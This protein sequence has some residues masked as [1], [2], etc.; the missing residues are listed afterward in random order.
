MVTPQISCWD[1]YSPSPD[2]YVRNCTSSPGAFCDLGNSTYGLSPVVNSFSGS[3]PNNSAIGVFG[4]QSAEALKNM[5][6]SPLQNG[7]SYIVSAMVYN[8]SGYSSVYNGTFNPNADPVLVTIASLPSFASING[9]NILCQFTVNPTNTWVSMTQT[10]VFTQPSSHGALVFW[11]S[12]GYNFIDEVSLLPLPTTTFVIPNN[13]ACGNGSLTNLAQFATSIPGVFSGPGV[14]SVTN[15]TF[16]SYNFSP[17]AP[18]NYPIGF[19]Y[20][21]SAG[22]VNTLWQNVIVSNSTTI[23]A[24]ATQRCLNNP[25]PASIQGLCSNCNSSASYF[26]MPGA[27][28]GSQI[29]VSPN[30]TQIYTLTVNT[31]SCLQ[32]STTQVNVSYSCCQLLQII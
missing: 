14:T 23:N 16:T 10:F 29:A 15:G 22:C 1:E 3:S 8:V 20:T 25:T 6:S 26:W 19:T 27:L 12:G 17:T 4:G 28:S 11:T 18:G 24:L 31:G 9:A 32:S 21:S 13:N 2:L 7:T 30:V 5:L